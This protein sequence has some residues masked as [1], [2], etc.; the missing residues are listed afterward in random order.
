MQIFKSL[1]RRNLKKAKETSVIGEF[2]RSFNYPHG[3]GVK[4]KT[5]FSSLLFINP[6]RRRTTS[7]RSSL[8]SLIS[9]KI[10]LARDF[11]AI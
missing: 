2:A 11:F 10:P 3:R 8:F 7:L 4:S 1:H 6:R 9:K 5:D